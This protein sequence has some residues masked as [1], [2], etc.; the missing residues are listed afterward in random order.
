MYFQRLFDFLVR[1]LPRALVC[2]DSAVAKCSARE[3]ICWA[4]FNASG[5]E[6]DTRQQPYEGKFK[7]GRAT[8]R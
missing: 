1:R 2:C 8:T 6:R 3:Y 4:P 5:L 7:L